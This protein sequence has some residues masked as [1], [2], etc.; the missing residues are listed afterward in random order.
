MRFLPQLLRY[1]I[2]ESK[3]P[4]KVGSLLSSSGHVYCP[5]FDN[6]ETF[7]P[8]GATGTGDT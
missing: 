8:E 4:T 6:G 1:I 5:G 2:E 3:D 7:G